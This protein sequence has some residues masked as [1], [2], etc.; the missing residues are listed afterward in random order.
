MYSNLFL[1][2]IFPAPYILGKI[3]VVY[4]LSNVIAIYRGYS[5]IYKREKYNSFPI[6]PIFPIFPTFPHGV[7]L[8]KVGKDT[9]ASGK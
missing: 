5:N 4:A 6:F 2:S 1:P 7:Y 8:F 3:E 9:N